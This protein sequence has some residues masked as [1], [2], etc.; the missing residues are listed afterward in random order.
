MN[1]P[2]RIVVQPE[3]SIDWLTKAQCR[4]LGLEAADLWF[5]SYRSG[6][7][8]AK[9]RQRVEEWPKEV[10]AGC[11]V[12]AE[13]RDYGKDDQYGIY[14]GIAEGERFPKTPRK[15]SNAGA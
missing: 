1:D 2:Y 7:T 15:F 11:P 12:K 14:G 6:Q 4:T 3:Q 8:A 5:P 10:C 9:F 13:C